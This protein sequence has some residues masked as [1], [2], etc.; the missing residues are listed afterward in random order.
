M[1]FS[2][3]FLGTRLE[4]ARCHHHPN[5]KWSQDDFY[6]FAAFFGSMKQKGAGLSPPISAGTE[7]FYFAPGGTVK[8]PVTEAVMGPRPLDGAPV[9][10]STNSD[11]RRILA[12]WLTQPDNPFFAKAAVNRLWASFFGR[13]FLE[14]VDDFRVSNPAANEPLLAALA[15]DFANHG[16]D[17]KHL[18]RTILSSRLYQLSSIPQPFNLGDTRNFSRAYRRRLPAEVMLDAV[19]D[20]TGAVDQFHGSPPGSRAVQTWSYK[21][22]SQFM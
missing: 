21:V 14:P 3:L 4:C 9:S 18:I 13:G 16:Y 2:Q 8:H 12:D 7:T 1:M 19:N 10:L 5:E 20:V 6:Q 17:F 11:P 22:S 15:R